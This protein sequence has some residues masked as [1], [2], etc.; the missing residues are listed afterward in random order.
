MSEYLDKLQ[1]TAAICDL[2][3]LCEWRY[4]KTPS[5]FEDKIDQAHWHL[6]HLLD[7][8]GADWILQRLAATGKYKPPLRN[9]E[10]CWLCGSYDFTFEENTATCT[11][12]GAMYTR[13]G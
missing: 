8:S 12:C 11:S 3:L 1:L 13:P 2:L 6:L 4:H 5:D 7:I 10:S 9:H